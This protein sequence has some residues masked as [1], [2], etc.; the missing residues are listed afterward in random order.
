MTL[1][2]IQGLSELKVD[3]ILVEVEYNILNNIYTKIYRL[4]ESV[5][6]G[7]IWSIFYL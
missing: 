1:V 6:S 5:K 3:K 4:L 7:R 2:H